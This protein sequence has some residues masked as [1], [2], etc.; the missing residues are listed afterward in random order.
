MYE[1]KKNCYHPAQIL[2]LPK[3]L[4]MYI[5]YFP[6]CLGLDTDNEPV[7]FKDHQESQH[8]SSINLCPLQSL[9]H[10]VWSQL[11]YVLKVELIC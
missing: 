11:E 5:R 3:Y 6:F 8:L 7:S 1:V 2:I 10:S 9:D 4:K